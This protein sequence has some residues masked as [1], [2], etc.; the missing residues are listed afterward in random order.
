[1]IISEYDYPEIM[2][3]G[4]RSGLTLFNDFIITHTLFGLSR[5]GFFEFIETHSWF[6]LDELNQVLNAPV[7]NLRAVLRYLVR[8]EVIHREGNCFFVDE[9]L[10]TCLKREL[11]FLQW[12]VGGYQSVL[13][14]SA[15]LIRGTRVFGQNTYRNN[16]WMAWGSA[17]ISKVYTDPLM[18]ELLQRVDVEVIGDI[19][20]G[21]GLRLV[22]ICRQ[23]PSVRGLGIDISP[24][25]CEL[26]RYN[27]ATAGLSDRIDVIEAEAESWVKQERYRLDCIG[28]QRTKPADVLMCFAMFHDLLNYDGK[29]ERF[30]AEV[31]EGLGSGGYL[32]IQDQCQSNVDDRHPHQSW[33]D[34]FELLHHYMNQRLFPKDHYE[35]LFEQAGFRI[36]ER[37]ES[38]IPANWLYLLQVI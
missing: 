14:D 6:T 25:C 17:N 13:V 2:S 31:R 34:G 27:I 9:Q 10:F 1:M 12:L 30:L 15:D 20:C 37:I 4:T 28:A 38:D 29:A 3:L 18:Y 32:M 7:A 22:A 26:A 24:T 21:S 5:L 19:G 8:M 11:G 16:H 23:L 35:R 33:T 36:V